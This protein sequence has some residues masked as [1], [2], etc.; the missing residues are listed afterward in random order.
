MKTK[1]DIIREMD[2]NTMTKK[3]GVNVPQDFDK[4]DNYKVYECMIMETPFYDEKTERGA[5]YPSSI[6]D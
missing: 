5:D 2:M 3:P 4:E 6:Y 1:A